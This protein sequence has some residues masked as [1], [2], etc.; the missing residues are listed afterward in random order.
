M[1]AGFVRLYG[2]EAPTR[3]V[4]GPRQHMHRLLCL[5]PN[6]DSHAAHVL[7]DAAICAAGCAHQ[8]PGSGAQ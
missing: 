2:K 1:N 3:L 7:L 6:S 5:C 8:C 4:R